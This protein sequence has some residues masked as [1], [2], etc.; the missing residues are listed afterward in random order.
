MFE[1]CSYECTLGKVMTLHTRTHTGEKPFKCDFEGCEYSS[2]QS[3][4]LKTHKRTHTGEKPYKCD[5]EGCIQSFKSGSHLQVHKRI[6]TDEKPFKC[7]FEGCEYSSNEQGNLV[8]HKRIHTGEKPYKCDFEGCEYSS[9]QSGHLVTHKRTHTGE[10]PYKCIECEY[11]S[12]TSTSLKEHIYYYHTEKGN[13]ERKREEVKIEKILPKDS[14][15]REHH[16]NFKCIDYGMTFSRLDFLLPYWKGRGHV[17]IE[18]DEGQHSHVSQSCETI[19]M[20]NVISSWVIDG[21]SAPVVW[22]RY[23]PHAY[24]INGT[25]VRTP[26]KERHEKLIKFLNEISFE[27]VPDVRVVYMFYDME[28]GA[29]AVIS[30]SEYHPIVRTWVQGL[31][32]S[33]V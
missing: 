16:V 30:D 32:V 1:G 25:L 7:D 33:S 9:T 11:A 6:H 19:R 31:K 15:K 28:D 23:N 8:S 22:I 12:T 2:T 29:P 27:N 26:T 17:I 21:S 13:Q 14:F 20:N 24:R 10:K 4:A 5:F 3:S 18:V